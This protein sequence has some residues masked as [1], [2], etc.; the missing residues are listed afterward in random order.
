M[1]IYTEI[2]AKSELFSHPTPKPEIFSHLT[3]NT[4]NFSIPP[5]TPKPEIFS[6]HTRLMQENGDRLA[7]TLTINKVK[8]RWALR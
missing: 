6:H 7:D 1:T 2:F 3:P 8:K 4:E 5:A